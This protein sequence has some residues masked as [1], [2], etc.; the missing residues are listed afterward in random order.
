MNQLYVLVLDGQ[1]RRKLHAPD[2]KWVAGVTANPTRPGMNWRTYELRPAGTV[3]G[4]P[5]RR[6]GGTPGPKAGDY[7]VRD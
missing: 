3:D 7:P 2:C 1:L 5:C 4:V 6:C